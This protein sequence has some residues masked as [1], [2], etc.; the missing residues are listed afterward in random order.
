MSHQDKFDV[1]V[2]GEIN[3]DLILKGNVEPS[4]GQVEQIVDDANLVMGSSAVIFACG[5]AR[6]GSK[7]DLYR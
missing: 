3:A 1:V 2:V 7:D 4:F 5:V 6:T